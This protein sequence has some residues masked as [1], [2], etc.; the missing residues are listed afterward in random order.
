MADKENTMV[1]KPTIVSVKRLEEEQD[2]TAKLEAKVAELE[3]QASLEKKDA[4][5]ASSNGHFKEGRYV[6]KAIKDFTF[7]PIGTRT[8]I[9]KDRAG[10]FVQENTRKGVKVMF[11][12]GT[13]EISKSFADSIHVPLEHI[14]LGMDNDRCAGVKYRKVKAPGF[15]PTE[16]DLKYAKM[17]D[18][19]A[20]RRREEKRRMTKKGV[21][22]KRN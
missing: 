6:Y 16:D 5:P 12:G 1:K 13:C 18:A 9:V 2:K 7:Y 3:R 15:T 19:T 22:A 14:I 17:C 11:I 20:D 21:R 4:S 8:Q 10:N